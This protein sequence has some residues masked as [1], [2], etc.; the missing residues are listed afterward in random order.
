M[1]KNYIFLL[2]TAFATTLLITSVHA[3][4][5]QSPKELNPI[6][7]PI[8]QLRNQEILEQA[9]ID[10]DADIEINNAD[11]NADGQ[12]IS[13]P[14]DT[15]YPLHYAAATGDLEVFEQIIANTPNQ[16][17]A[18]LDDHNLTPM[19]YA[20]YFGH[21]DIVQRL[22]R[23]NAQLIT[24]HGGPISASP[25]AYAIHTYQLNTVDALLTLGAD[26]YE[27]IIDQNNPHAGPVHS[28][29]SLR[30]DISSTELVTIFMQHGYQFRN[31]DNTLH[32]A[33]FHHNYELMTSLINH[34]ARINQRDSTGH[35]PLYYA[36]HNQPDNEP[37]PDEQ[38]FRLQ[39]TIDLLAA[40]LNE[41]VTQSSHDSLLHLAAQ[42]NNI[43]AAAYILQ[44]R[45]E[46][47]HAHTTA[48][49]TPLHYAALANN[50]DMIAFLIDQAHMPVDETN[51]QEITALHFA[52][53]NGAQEAITALITRGAA[54]DIQYNEGG[55]PY[56][57][58][59]IYDEENN[60]S[61]DS[62]NSLATF[63]L[64][65]YNQHHQNDFI[66]AAFQLAFDALRRSNSL[67]W[68]PIMFTMHRKIQAH[69]F[70][71]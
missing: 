5:N 52:V 53:T 69:T 39:E 10:Q 36:I 29:L 38:I 47:V 35:L 51:N 30:T 23:A 65:E 67:F 34:G 26:P 42:T 60:I 13:I 12:L 18:D 58:A 32:N 33:A 54:I 14:N 17:F 21:T 25:L 1:N 71:Y 41:P 44:L 59:Q 70:T 49:N 8:E 61:P 57:E 9:A 19:H 55:T 2:S 64:R 50:A 31:D 15:E 46:L 7:A 27:R 4:D 43:L 3:R 20:A 63:V 45:P 40:T 68:L 11:E 16:T 28:L 48:G 24:V 62:E 6:F 37:V 22:H 56:T 66:P